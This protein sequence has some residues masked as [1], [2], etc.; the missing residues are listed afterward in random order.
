MVPL[1]S[2]FDGIFPGFQNDSLLSASL[3]NPFVRSMSSTRFSSSSKSIS[4][5]KIGLSG[6]SVL[7]GPPCHMS[8]QAGLF[9]WCQLT[10]PQCVQA[11]K[12]VKLQIWVSKRPKM[13]KNAVFLLFKRK[14]KQTSGL[15]TLF[16]TCGSLLR[17]NRA[18]SGQYG[19]G[20]LVQAAPAL[21]SRR[22]R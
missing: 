7:L 4:P 10:K 8:M 12:L 6:R 18:K 16:H 13:A 22:R 2:V 3:E 15:V 5:F 9:L 11:L 17:Q 14:Q 19:A 21:S 20:A 1:K